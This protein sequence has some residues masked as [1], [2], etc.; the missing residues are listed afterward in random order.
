MVEGGDAALIDR[1]YRSDIKTQLD[2]IFLIFL[3]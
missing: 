1:G 2:G 3:L